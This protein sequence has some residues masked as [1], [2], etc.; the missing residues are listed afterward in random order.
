MA[1]YRVAETRDI[2]GMKI[3]R[4]AVKEN[5][6]S[7]PDLI[8]TFDYV[9]FISVRGQGWVCEVEDQI[10]GFAFADLQDENIWAL[11]ILPAFEGQGIGRALQKLML[12]W[13]FEAGK[14][15]VWLGT[16]PGTRA[17]KFYA[18][19]GWERNGWHG[20]EV[21]FEMTKARWHSVRI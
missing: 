4:M 13:Y 14:N 17:E 12:D 6:L 9:S 18:Q 21:K 7:N 15:Y 19:T 10:V 3:V 8:K 1:N 16:S 20:E 5:V 11:F 2:P